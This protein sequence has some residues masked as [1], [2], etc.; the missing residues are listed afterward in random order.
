M[1]PAGYQ[2]SFAESGKSLSRQA[3]P[4]SVRRSRLDRKVFRSRGGEAAVIDFADGPANDLS[5][6]SNWNHFGA[7]YFISRKPSNNCQLA[8]DLAEQLDEVR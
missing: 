5:K 4:K 3:L 6:L 1:D 7:L 8:W 2:W